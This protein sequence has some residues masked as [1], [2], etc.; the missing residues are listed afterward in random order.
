MT[1]S[2][3]VSV[4]VWYV[5]Q[6]PRL[7]VSSAGPQVS[8]PLPHDS[9]PTAAACALPAPAGVDVLVMH[10]SSWRAVEDVGV[11]LTYIAACS[12]A[13]EPSS[14]TR[15]EDYL[16]TSEAVADPPPSRGAV[17]RHALRHL[18]FLV[19][20]DPAVRERLGT[21]SP[22]LAAFAPEVAGVLAPPVLPGT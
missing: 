1:G 15:V 21:W 8:G 2:L 12:G 17:L 18:S 13:G 22:H 19:Q 6:S 5:R 20:A 4:E 10:S 16:S 14:W 9:D 11:L 7:E 3:T